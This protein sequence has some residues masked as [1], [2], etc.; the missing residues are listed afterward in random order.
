MSNA[1]ALAT[2]VHDDPATLAG[3]AF[4]KM[5]GS[6]NDFVFFDGRTAPINALILPQVIR[7]ICNR[8][9]GIGADGIVIL[10]PE[11]GD[12][13]VRIDYF[14]SDGT[15]ADLCGNASLCS[16][17]MAADLGLAPPSGMAMR[18]PAGI[19][20]S[21]IA[22]GIPRIA[23]PSVHDIR[24]ELAIDPMETELRIGYSVV[25]VPHLVVLCAD[26]EAAPLMERGPEL[27]HHV[28][29]GP[30]G[31]NV[32][33]VSPRADGSWRYRTF[34]RGVEGETLACG[35]GAVATAILLASWGLAASPVSILTSSGRQLRVAFSDSHDWANGIHPTLEGEGRVVFR[36]HMAT[37]TV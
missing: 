8:H 27:R 15:A 18:T 33:W 10:S 4:V 17:V 28:A 29:A 32:N 14:N 20:R 11:S 12:A 19:L 3:V 30:A 37:L 25:G 36:G 34:E 24:L 2:P 7:S 26:A 16:T 5:S 23:L 31:A 21:E 9:N 13:D 22:D 35:T 1:H 6:G